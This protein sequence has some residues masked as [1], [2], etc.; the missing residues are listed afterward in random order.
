M[1]ENIILVT[2]TYTIEERKKKVVDSLTF[3]KNEAMHYLYG[4]S[5]WLL[6]VSLHVCGDDFNNFFTCGVLSFIDKFHFVY[7]FIPKLF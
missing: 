3:E 6:C 1:K 7:L 5:E 2:Y 4:I